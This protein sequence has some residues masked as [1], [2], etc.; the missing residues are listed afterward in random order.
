MAAGGGERETDG[1]KDTQVHSQE[2]R[3]L[4]CDPVHVGLALCAFSDSG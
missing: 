4:V 1:L 3:V 2:E